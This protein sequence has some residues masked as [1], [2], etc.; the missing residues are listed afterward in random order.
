[1]DKIGSGGSSSVHKAMDT[2]S[3]QLVAIKKVD[4][5]HT[6][7]SEAE[8]FRNEINL[9]HKLSGNTRIVKIIDCQERTERY[10]D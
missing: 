10:V 2:E 9:L 6:S 5:T 8:G 7:R 3:H 1:M 4:L